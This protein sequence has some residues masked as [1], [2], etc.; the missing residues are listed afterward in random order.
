MLDDMIACS[1]VSPKKTLE[2]VI[3]RRY[4]KE[5]ANQEVRMKWYNNT[6][7]VILFC[8]I[9]PPVGIVFIWIHPNWSQ[10]VKI[11]WSL[12]VGFYS[13]GIARRRI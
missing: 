5:H 12:I 11:I 6:L 7:V 2:V 3:S 4:A 13:M 1:M 10:K 9:L 8:I